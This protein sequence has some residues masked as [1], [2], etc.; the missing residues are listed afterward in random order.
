MPTRRHE[1]SPWKYY[2]LLEMVG[3][4]GRG[5][6]LAVDI[7]APPMVVFERHVPLSEYTTREHHAAIRLSS[8]SKQKGAIDGDVQALTWLVERLKEVPPPSK[9]SQ[10]CVIPLENVR[11]LPLVA[12]ES[13]A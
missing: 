4:H 7:E 6:K 2:I 5:V 9:Q 12:K 1:S 11:R 3:R 10:P 8:S 13:R